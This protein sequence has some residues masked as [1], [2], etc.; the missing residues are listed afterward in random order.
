MDQIKYFYSTGK[1]SMGNST[2]Q[3]ACAMEYDQQEIGLE[4]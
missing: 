1:T 2:S 4:V 3:S